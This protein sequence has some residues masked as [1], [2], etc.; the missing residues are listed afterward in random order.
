M[1]RHARALLLTA[2][3]PR[4]GVRLQSYLRDS[5]VLRLVGSSRGT[6]SMHI[7][8]HKT[9]ATNTNPSRQVTLSLLTSSARALNF[10]SEA[11]YVDHSFAALD[12]YLDE[13]L[14]PALYLLVQRAECLSHGQVWPG[15]LCSFCATN[16]RIAQHS[17][18]NLQ[19]DADSN[20]N[21][22]LLYQSACARKFNGKSAQ[23]TTKS[24]CFVAIQHEFEELFKAQFSFPLQEPAFLVRIPLAESQSVVPGSA[25]LSQRS[26]QAVESFISEFKQEN[27]GKEYILHSGHIAS[28]PVTPLNCVSGVYGAVGVEGAKGQYPDGSRGRERDPSPQMAAWS[29]LAELCSLETRSELLEGSGLRMADD[30]T[31]DDVLTVKGVPLASASSRTPLT[32]S[33][34]PGRRSF[35]TLTHTQRS[36]TGLQLVHIQS[37]EER[38]QQL[39]FNQKLQLSITEDMSLD[40]RIPLYRGF[41]LLRGG[42]KCAGFAILAFRRAIMMSA[43][44]SPMRRRAEKKLAQMEQLARENGTTEQIQE[45]FDLREDEDLFIACRELSVPENYMPQINTRLVQLESR[46]NWRAVTFGVVLGV[47]FGSIIIGVITSV[48]QSPEFPALTSALQS[49]TSVLK[50]QE[51]LCVDLINLNQLLLAHADSE[52]ITAIHKH[53][54]DSMNHDLSS[55][56][57]TLEESIKAWQSIDNDVAAL[58]QTL[59][60]EVTANRALL[61]Q[62]TQKLRR[63]VDVLHLLILVTNS[64]QK[65]EFTFAQNKMTNFIAEEKLAA[66]CDNDQTHIMSSAVLP[67]LK[68]AFEVVHAN[69]QAHT[70]LSDLNQHVVCEAAR[71]DFVLGTL[72]QAQRDAA[73]EGLN[74]SVSSFMH[75]R[76]MVL[77]QLGRYVESAK[78]A[79]EG[80]LLQRR[81]GQED[82]EL[83]VIA[84]RALVGLVTEADA[85]ATTAPAICKSPQATPGPRL[86]SPLDPYVPVSSRLSD[87]TL[88]A[89][90]QSDAPSNDL[91]RDKAANFAFA[92]LTRAIQLMPHDSRAY[93]LRGRLSR[94]T[95]SYVFAEQ[96][97]NDALLR[98]PHM[99]EAIRGMM[100]LLL[101]QGQCDEA[102]KYLAVSLLPVLTDGEE[103]KRRMDVMK[104]FMTDHPKANACKALLSDEVRFDSSKGA[105]L[106]RKLEEDAFQWR[107][108]RTK[109][110]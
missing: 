42:R 47:V 103:T 45:L 102:L 80:I 75:T 44:N 38:W 77:H 43:E 13:H 26:L 65:G 84:G 32:R 21:R 83:Y 96:D 24:V 98:D 46:V 71:C 87:T 86:V 50:S 106:M 68:L 41:A 22:P 94:L 76:A 101:E 36:S 15:H 78:L 23:A 18:M 61:Q 59:S 54:I 63:A 30:R 56:M 17:V 10:S 93:A 27:R 9:V 11:A 19:P 79:Q 91:S 12:E 37:F 69:L 25:A 35:S 95:K 92:Y 2:L 57:R 62:H 72:E 53:R 108:Q 70:L 5:G 8:T 85:L 29:L 58:D 109:S 39:S 51:H 89:S 73:A 100:F 31:W 97:F 6:R 48:G 74:S 4:E 28:Q 64:Q 40:A 104:T 49:W 16:G 60:R 33:P 7:N 20:Y 90:A 88:A 52:Y 66:Q 99:D 105:D 34:G 82:G 55:N 107:R 14:A 110:N 1:L 81:C 67:W 3:Q